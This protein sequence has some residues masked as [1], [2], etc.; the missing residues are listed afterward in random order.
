[1]SN[2]S[3]CPSYL[4]G[5]PA[6]RAVPSPPPAVA[7]MPLVIPGLPASPPCKRKLEP[8]A[9]EDCDYRPP[10]KRISPFLNTPKQRR[11]ERRKLYR[12]SM[13]KLRDIDDS[14]TFLRRSV[15]INNLARRMQKELRDEKLGRYPQCA[16]TAEPEMLAPCARRQRLM[17]P[18]PLP[19]EPAP[20]AASPVSV[21]VLY[22]APPPVAP[23]PPS[24]FD[25]SVFSL[26]D[27]MTDDMSETLMRT[28]DALGGTVMAPQPEDL[29][30]TSFSMGVGGAST[31]PP[32]SPDLCSSS[33]SSSSS[34]AGSSSPVDCSGM[35][36]RDRQIL[37]EMDAVFNS[38][39]NM[40]AESMGG[41]QHG[42]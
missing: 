30:M 41:T 27:K 24:I 8:A 7:M 31:T 3:V 15:L 21:P 4:P 14:E 37:G 32:S 6:V 18:P 42:S 20:A 29:T 10:T 13:N 19:L 28:V 40:F 1:M 26:T 23:L 22:G 5:A 9:A 38:L 25:D 35:T 12:I 17:M 34:P 33:S 16:R 36:E 39:L 2:G 11:D